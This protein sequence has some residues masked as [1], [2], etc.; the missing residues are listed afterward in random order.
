MSNFNDIFFKE[1]TVPAKQQRGYNV[2]SDK[3]KFTFV[4][5]ATASEA[6]EKSGIKAPF[7][8]EPS[9]FIK[10]NVFAQSEI[11]EV[12]KEQATPATPPAAPAT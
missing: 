10:K 12:K 7:K 11:A 4:E 2:Y 3:E 9:G 8:I 5:A 1:R 6:I